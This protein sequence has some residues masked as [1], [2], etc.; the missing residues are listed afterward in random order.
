MKQLVASV[1]INN[2]KKLGFLCFCCN[3]A[4]SCKFNIS[5]GRK[6]KLATEGILNFTSK[7]RGG[8]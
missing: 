7:K 2:D 8:T 3:G 1:H 5:I 6:R 4:M